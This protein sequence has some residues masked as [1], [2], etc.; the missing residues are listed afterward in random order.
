MLI[1]MAIWVL[2]AALVIPYLLH[3]TKHQSDTAG[4]AIS[5]RIGQSEE[6][7]AERLLKDSAPVLFVTPGA[8]PSTE[9]SPLETSIAARTLTDA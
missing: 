5:Q 8:A 4:A 6:E 9:G 2:S 3:L 7:A 1:I